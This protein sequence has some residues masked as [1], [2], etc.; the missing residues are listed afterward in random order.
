MS[1][2]AVNGGAPV[3]DGKTNPWPQWPLW[4]AREEGVGLYFRSAV[5][6]RAA[7]LGTLLGVDIVPLM[8]IADEYWIDLPSML[9][10]LPVAI[11]NGL[12]PLLFTLAGLAAVYLGVRK[13]LKA[14]HSEALVGL[15]TFVMVSLVVLTIIGIFFRGPNMALVLPF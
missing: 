9:P 7:L 10:G 15:F 11:T 6:R 5:G 1:Q 4:D 8:V 2:L 14:S 3:R 12:L 13:L